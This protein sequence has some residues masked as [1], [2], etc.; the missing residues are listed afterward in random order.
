[1]LFKIVA[2]IIDKGPKI[3]A[4]TDIEFEQ[5]YT[6]FFKLLLI[7]ETFGVIF[8]IVYKLIYFLS[9]S[10]INIYRHLK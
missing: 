9:T 1:M 4:I 8:K 2:I 10:E 6:V 5:F 7:V 3:V